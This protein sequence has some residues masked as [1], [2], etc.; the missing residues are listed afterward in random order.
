MPF[1]KLILKVSGAQEAKARG[2]EQATE[3]VEMLSDNWDQLQDKFKGQTE[4]EKEE[5]MDLFN[6]AVENLGDTL[7]GDDAKI[8]DFASFVDNLEDEESAAFMGAIKK[9]IGIEA[10]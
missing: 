9:A 2:T 8:D 4:A 5:M 7:F 6:C 3:M 1:S 10:E